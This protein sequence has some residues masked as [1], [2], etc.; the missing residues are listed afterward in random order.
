M[1]RE[2]RKTMVRMVSSGVSCNDGEGRPKLCGAG[3]LRARR[4]HSIQLCKNSKTRS[5]ECVRARGGVE[6]D[7]W[8]KGLTVVAGIEGFRRRR[9]GGPTSKLGSLGHESERAFRDNI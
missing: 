7:Y 8:R 4:L 6:T 2:E 5:P 9:G 1:Q 3:E